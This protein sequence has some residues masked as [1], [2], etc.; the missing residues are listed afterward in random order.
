[1]SRSNTRNTSRM[2]LIGNALVFQA[3]N[4]PLPRALRGHAD[5]SQFNRV[6][7]KILYSCISGKNRIR[8][9]ALIIRCCQLRSRIFSET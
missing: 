5:A 8:C 9:T 1:M 3:L 2:T 7:Y 6:H 4:Q